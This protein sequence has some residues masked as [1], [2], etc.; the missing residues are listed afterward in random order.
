MIERATQLPTGLSREVGR[1]GSGLDGPTLLCMCGMH[2]N[3]PAGIAAIERVLAELIEKRVPLRG[4]FVSLR[5]NL[6]ALAA[7]R[8]YIDQDLNRLWTQATMNRLSRADHSPNAEEL[9]LLELRDAFAEIF[10]RATGEVVFLDLHTSSADG[11]PFLFVGDTLRNRRIAFHYPLPVI[12][13]LEEQLDGGLTEFLGNRGCLTL[14]FEAGQHESAVAADNMEAA[15]WFALVAGGLVNEADAPGL[16]R[17]RER[18]VAAGRGLPSVLEVRYRYPVA[19]RAAF[20]MRP[21]YTNFQPVRRGELLA[22]DLDGPVRARES[23]HVLLPLYQALGDD[24]FFL[25][26][27]FRG[28]WISVSRWLRTLGVDRVAVR[29]PGVECVGSRDSLRVRKRVARWFVLELFH[30][31]GY[32]RVREEGGELLL[33]RRRYDLR[34][35]ARV[36]LD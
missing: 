18:L 30:L 8:R 3:E 17:F 5:G 36:E 28:F 22:Q 10:G 2:G 33:S 21:G 20:A 15:I 34:P 19:N 14:G 16:H 1:Y 4:E 12:L 26:R 11:E 9:E 6:K 27:P 31:L 13:G 29:L 23:G 35:P 24:G 32:R 25:V 7:G